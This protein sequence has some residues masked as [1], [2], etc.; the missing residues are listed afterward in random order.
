MGHD[1]HSVEYK[2]KGL[3]KYSIKNTLGLK[4]V[5]SIFSKKQR[6]ELRETR[7]GC[8]KAVFLFPLRVVWWMICLP[9]KLLGLFYKSRAPRWIKVVFT[10]ILVIFLLGIYGYSNS[11][12]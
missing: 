1:K 12:K 2:W 7:V 11:S 4:P 5:N 10:I 8:L 3:D 9:F 6:E